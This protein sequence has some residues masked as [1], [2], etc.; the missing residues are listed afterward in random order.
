MCRCKSFMAN[1]SE[2]TLK[3]SAIVVVSFTKHN[4]ITFEILYKRNPQF[5]LVI[6]TIETKAYTCI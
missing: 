2:P 1:F 6:K 4:A 5:P 3:F